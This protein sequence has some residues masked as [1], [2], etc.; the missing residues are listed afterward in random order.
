MSALQ[1]AHAATVDTLLQTAV[2]HFA[3]T[4]YAA[5]DGALERLMVR[6]PGHVEAL[7]LRGLTQHRM[8]QHALALVLLESALRLQPDH[9]AVL[10]NTGLVLRALGR[11]QEALACY[12]RAIALQPDFAQAWGNRGNALR[13]TGESLLAVDSYRKALD[14]QPGYA[15]SW[16]GLGLAYH[17]LARWQDAVAAF[18]RALQCQPDMAVACLDRGNALREL[19]V[20]PEALAAYDRAIALRPSY[21]QAW[22][23]RGVLLKR[24]GRMQDALDSYQQAI[25]LEP[26]FLDALVNCSTL[27]KEKMD[28]DASGAM[29]KRALLLDSD[30]SGAH[31]NLAICHL[32]RG[33]FAQG[34]AHYEWRWHTEQLRTAV[35]P[36]VAPL[37][38][39]SQSL[40][41]AAILLH[42]EQ[43][44]GDTVQFCRYAP[45]LKAMGA[46]VY[47][48]V[49]APLLPLLHS[50]DGVDLWLRQGD[51]LPHFDLHCPLLSLPRAMQTAPDSV[52]ARMPY[53][54]ADAGR[55]AAW[56][57]R[58]G[59]PQRLRVGLV[60]SGRP[61]H[62]NDHNRT[63][64][65]R[66]LAPLLSVDAEFHALQK[67]FRP[68]DLALN[69]EALGVRLWADALHS[70]ADTA[71]LIMHMD[72]VVAVDTSVAHVAAAL[73][74]PV[75]L[76]LP[77]SPDWRWLLGR[78]DSPWY[79]GMQLFRQG[80]DRSWPAVLDR[81]Q[82]ALNRQVLSGGL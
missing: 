72:L 21:A 69:P 8:G 15:Q 59:A 78:D 14:L 29:N 79:P 73:G 67:E 63:M 44:L 26:D 66:E 9:A 60:W 18:D 19:D 7:H 51:A 53:L 41:G 38:S 64:P 68:A 5:A 55:V 76:L 49:Q 70:F 80:A 61:E 56:A 23:N 27:L 33:D 1:P 42:A 34:F 13:D 10:S 57:Q 11:P 74:K 48:E 35:R 4:D 52:P 40:K 37:W 58:L 36:F 28:L 54:A 81:V 24:M 30:C 39:G 62:K 12:D 50:L 16:H 2:Q 71:A 82:V 31:L 20:F 46:R 22:S 75:W 6:S 77:Y 32:L 43:G 65:L 17:D 47:M 45:L 25:G 3:K